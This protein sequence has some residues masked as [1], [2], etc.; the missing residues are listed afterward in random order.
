MAAERL[1][2]I[3]N[4]APILLCLIGEKGDFE[5]VNDYW[6]ENLGWTVESMA[7]RNM[8]E[9]FYPDQEQRKQAMTFLNEASGEWKDFAIKAKSGKVINTSWAFV[10]LSNG[11]QMG[12]GTN[13]ELR[14]KLEEDLLKSNEKLK[15][16][17]EAV[18]F[19][20]WDWN[21]KS[22]ELVWD[23]YM[24]T[25]FEIDKSD[26]SGDYDAFEKTLHAEDAIRVKA[27]LAKIFEKQGTQFKSEF[28]VQ[29]KAGKWKSIS[30]AATCF[31]DEK[32]SIARLVGSNWD[33][34]QQKQSE[35]T[36]LQSAKMASLGE[37][38]SGIAHEI[39]N[40]LAIISAKSEFLQRQMAAGVVD[41][42]K[43]V[44]HL[45][46]IV[47]T[48]QRIARIIK[49]L[50][51]FSR[52]ATQ[53]PAFRHSLKAIATDTISLC[54]ERLKTHDIELR[55]DV[56]DDLFILARPAQISQVLLNLLN[57]AHDAIYNLQ[58]RWIELR[59]A[60]MTEKG[61][62]RITVTDSGAGIDAKVAAR[63]ME[64]FYTTK[65]VGEGTGLGLSVSSGLIQSHG[66]RLWY[67]SESKNTQFEIDL[68][69]APDEP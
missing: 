37:M 44:T 5:W 14:K 13:I 25:L 29:T 64:P 21:L 15:L 6:T 53:D 11:R 46:D 40:P 2:L 57:N 26:F 34:S 18:Q 4:H 23:K 47:K 60:R 3:S 12:I 38:A 28:R 43:F 56:P 58:E 48:T 20:V 24:Y 45:N 61:M 68:P 55:V 31:Y 30:A 22:G 16:A 42:E 7:G 67:N 41:T 35:L 17:I 66:G 50:R 33:I 65:S 1:A 49:G 8:L 10:R 39:N 51:T 52:D 36:L 59:A 9:E 27:E 69:E 54:I 19:G 62:I 63:I 32:G